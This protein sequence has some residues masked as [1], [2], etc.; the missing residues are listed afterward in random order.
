M[1]YAIGLTIIELNDPDMYL[2]IKKLNDDFA[3]KKIFRPYGAIDISPLWGHQ[4]FAPMGPP[5]LRPYGATDIA[6]LWGYRY[7]VP[8]G[9]L[10]T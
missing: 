9:T 5:I 6:P 1:D 3:V 10:N 2:C 4:Y 7:L 8:N